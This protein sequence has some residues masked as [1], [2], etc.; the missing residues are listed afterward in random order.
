MQKGL[1]TRFIIHNILYSIKYKNG[2]LDKLIIDNFNNYNLSSSDKKMINNV[3]FSSMR[4]N[5]YILKIIKEYAKKKI[6]N[7][8]YILLLSAL[9]QLIYLNFTDYA[10]INCSVELSKDKKLNASP[11][12]IN[13]I[14]KKILINKKR[15]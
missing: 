8:Q 1:Q 2:N 9:T 5:Y 10:V 12:F 7:H 6:S 4:Y 14:L 11:A 15:L 3:V 13:A